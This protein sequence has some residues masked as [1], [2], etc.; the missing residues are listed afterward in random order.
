MYTIEITGT[1]LTLKRNLV[2]QIGRQSIAVNTLA[3][4]AAKYRAYIDAGTNKH[5]T[6]PSS[7][8]K[9]CLVR[10]DGH[11]IADIS[12]NCRVWIADAQLEELY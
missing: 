6:V 10:E 3:E 9:L 4:A 1:E 11:P 7:E 8:A 12:Y 5:F 2:V